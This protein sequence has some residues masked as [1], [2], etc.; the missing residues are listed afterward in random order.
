MSKAALKP[1]IVTAKHINHIP[2]SMIQNHIYN[3]KHPDIINYIISLTVH[4]TSPNVYN[5]SVE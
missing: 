1:H 5:L 4:I 3:Y 2:D